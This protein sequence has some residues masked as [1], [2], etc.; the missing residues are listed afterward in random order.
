VARPWARSETCHRAETVEFPEE[1]GTY[2]ASRSPFA[3]ALLEDQIA[4]GWCL[5]PERQRPR[6]RIAITPV[7]S[8]GGR[9]NGYRDFV[10]LLTFPPCGYPLLPREFP[11][12]DLLPKLADDQGFTKEEHPR[13]SRASCVHF[14]SWYWAARRE[15]ADKERSLQGAQRRKGRN[16]QAPLP[17][18]H[19]R[20]TR[21]MDR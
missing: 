14:W 8:K 21:S 4:P 3:V 13:E 19:R 12:I 18:R 6:Y 9:L 11:T 10:C 17:P 2:L 7:R 20:P 5:P 15:T 1:A 16:R